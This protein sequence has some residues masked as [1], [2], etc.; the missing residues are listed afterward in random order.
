MA[1]KNLTA[2]RLRMVMRYDPATGLFERLIRTHNRWKPGPTAGTLRPNGYV[3]ICV[4]AKQYRAHQLAWLYMTGRW[5]IDDIDHINRE[6]SDNRWANL[7][8]ATRKENMEN[9]KTQHN[10]TSGFRGVYWDKKRLVWVAA[11]QHHKRAIYLGRFQTIVDAAAERLRAERAL[12]TY[13]R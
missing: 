4:L 13:H 1:K 8:E 11:I 5:P 9:A 3:I 6:R 2:Q 7:R 12:F 10:N